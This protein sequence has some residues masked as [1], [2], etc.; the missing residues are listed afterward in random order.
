MRFLMFY[1]HGI[2]NGFEDQIGLEDVKRIIN[3]VIDVTHLQEPDDLPV[4][5]ELSD[6]L[7]KIIAEGGGLPKASKKEIE[8]LHKFF[9]VLKR[10]TEEFLIEKIQIT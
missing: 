3:E 9:T 10:R 6:I 2:T 8:T 1:R 7:G 5:D 4:A